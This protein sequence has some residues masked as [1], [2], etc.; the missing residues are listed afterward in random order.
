MASFV[1]Y[2]HP[3]LRKNEFV[4]SN[5]KAGEEWKFGFFNGNR[6][7]GKD[8]LGNVAYDNMGNVVLGHFPV[9][10]S[11]KWPDEHED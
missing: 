4:L 5:V 6:T 8:R 2:K 3:E 11:N 1:C 9:I 7:L 10:K